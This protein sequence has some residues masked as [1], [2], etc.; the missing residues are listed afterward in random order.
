MKLKGI[1]DFSLGNFL[2]LRGFAPMGV[3]QIISKADDNI[4]RVPKDD[5]LKEVR[6]F[7]KKG[8]FVFFPEVVL[9]VGLDG[10]E[11]EA[12]SV[13][14]LYEQ[15]K[16]GEGSKSL[17]FANGLRL[18]T[19]VA[20]S[21]KREDIRAV[22]YFQVATV[23]FDASQPPI[24]SRID[25]N[26]RLAATKSTDTQVRERTTPFCIV[27]CRNSI[28]FR[29]FSRALFHNIN[30]KQVQLPKEHNL[31]LILDDAELFPDE[32]L[33]SDPSFGWPH[34]LA[35]QLYNK[36]DFDVLK[37]LKPFIETEPRS[38]LVDQFKFLIER[39]ALPINVSAVGKFKHS[40]GNVN[41]LL[42][43]YPALK[44]STNRGLLAALI[45]Y[46]LKPSVPTISFLHWVLDNHLHF[47]KDSNSADLISIFDKVLESRKR[48]VFVSMAFKKK[49]SEFHYKIIERVCDEVTTIYKLKPALKVERVDWFH[50]GTS[51]EINDK[52]IEMI[53]DCGL[54]IGDL[55]YCNPNVYHEIG[56]L[57]GKAKA[58]GKDTA[59]MLL[60][61]DES[62][63]DGK[64][65]FV[66]FN[67]RS[68]KHIPFKKT[69]VFEKALRINLERFFRLRGVST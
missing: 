10:G 43:S 21:R 16:S 41:A 15:V 25:G 51:Y 30:Y 55:T 32:K 3:L 65:R 49:A 22:Q 13:G 58:D 40:L 9:C 61:L 60:F 50:D 33:K 68:I 17:R 8:E 5:R 42:D 38:F 20:K 24:F 62:V 57:M 69:D 59:N 6:D 2:C 27:F 28:E 47:I 39:K 31:R 67:L 19:T 29:R 56:F 53:S 52:I 44:E 36:L 34:Y 66:G 37:N 14:K 7:L 12:D 63:P 1:L 26:H 46:Q 4:Q 48:T 11:I 23:E 54:L 18:R 45:Y 35:R 64:D